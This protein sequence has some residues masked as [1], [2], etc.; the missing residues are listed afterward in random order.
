[1][2]SR[3]SIRLAARKAGIKAAKRERIAAI[4]RGEKVTSINSKYGRK[5]A[6]QRRG[7]FAPASPFHTPKDKQND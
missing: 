5:K 4:Q 2:P 7:Y 6:A 3:K 1:M